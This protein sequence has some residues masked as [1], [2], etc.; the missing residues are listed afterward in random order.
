MKAK[1]D[2]LDRRRF[3]KNIGAAGLSSLLALPKV[4]AETPDANAPAKTA[5]AKLPQVPKRQLGRT[6]VKIPILSL[7]ANRLD[8]QIILRNCFKWGVTYWDTSHSYMGGKSELEIGRFVSKNQKQR[9]KLFI[10]TKASGAQNEKD[11][12]ERLQSSLER[13]NTDF[14][15]LYFVH[16]LEE[17]EQLTT[18][19]EQWVK[20]AK[21]RGVIRFFGFSTHK[22]M[23][24]NLAAAA[25]LDW[26]DA[27][28]TSYNFRLMQDKKMQKAVQACYDSGIGLVAM[29]TLGLRTG[30]SIETD[31]DKKITGHFIK[32]GFTETQ[33]AIKAVL[34][35]ERFSSA[36]VGMR[37]ITELTSNIAAALDKRKLSKRDSKVLAE[38]AG[39]TCSGYCAGCAH[40]CNSALPDNSYVSDI[41]RY[42]MYYN[43]YGRHQ[44]AKKL[45][46]Q[47]PADVRKRLLHT[48][49]SGAEA[50]CPQHLPIR[51]LIAEAV[52]SLA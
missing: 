17:P 21:K 36:C 8:D 46:A 42:L 25:K 24:D 16:G 30:I 22:N 1:R 20:Q 49:Y 52:S 7:G 48:D 12:E 50:R 10:V 15:D 19:L 47:I 44:E 34:A 33:A 5:E 31:E 2:L 41:M 18:K 29:K 3:L 35:D 13:T 27:I 26:I 37:S 43:S 28:M 6:G 9:G 32:Q 4:E 11:V 14:I 38:Y 45:F 39:A 23:A 40:I 51:K